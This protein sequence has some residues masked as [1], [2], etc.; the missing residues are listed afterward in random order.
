MQTNRDELFE[1]RLDFLIEIYSAVGIGVEFYQLF[2]QAILHRL[3]WTFL[4]M[5]HER[6][7][8]ICCEDFVGQLDGTSTQQGIDY[9]RGDVAYG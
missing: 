5:P 1:P 4:E 6:Y 7:A 9:I 2:P 3:V 8:C